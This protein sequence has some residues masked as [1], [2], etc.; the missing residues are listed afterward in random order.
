MDLEPNPKSG[1]RPAALALLVVI[2]AACSAEHYRR[3]ADE[4]VYSILA[5]KREEAGLPAREFT[6]DPPVDPLRDRLLARISQLQQESGVEGA[7][8]D[9][10][11]SPSGPF[12]QDD[13]AAAADAP[14]VLD[15]EDCLRIAA[16]NSREFQ[17]EKE[18]VYL[19]ALSLTFE[20]FVFQNQYFGGVLGTAGQTLPEERSGTVTADTGFT[21]RLASGANVVFDIGATLFRA[22]VGD[23]EESARSFL[24]L[25]ITQPLLRGA[26]RTIVQEPL[27]QSERDALYAIRQFEQFKLDLAVQ[28][29]SGMYRV[30][31]QADR[32]RNALANL[33]SLTRSRERIE[34]LAEAGRTPQFQVDQAEQDE[35]RAKN[36]WIS[37]VQSYETSLDRFKLQLGLP[38]DA[39]L[40]L[41]QS[42]LYSLRDAG[43]REIDID[44]PAAVAFALDNRLD[45]A[46]DLDRVI[47]ATRRV[48]VAKDALRTALSVSFSS[49]VNNED[50][51]LAALEFGDGT[52][53]VGA[54]LDLPFNRVAERN[55]YRS[56]LISL[57]RAERSAEAAEDNVKFDVRN[58]ARSL[59]LAEESFRIQ[60]VAL[61]LAERRVESTALLQQAGRAS[62]RDLLESQDALLESQDGLTGAL[63]DHEIARLQL[64]RDMGLLTVDQEGLSYDTSI[65]RFI[66][67]GY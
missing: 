47:D 30:L 49:R 46:N 43:L 1:R 14:L 39:D 9:L 10:D 42:E 60:Q 15:L 58:S 40:Q 33:Q 7:L 66:E 61:L 11:V 32:V 6:I 5:A 48:N 53:L 36:R 17:R 18:T 27:T 26:G 28:I 63:V 44:T 31:Q 2:T 45:F 22:F 65:D 56:S 62:T 25:T 19:A 37:Q 54:D 34:A 59:E 29:A 35:L 13:D 4:E 24:D 57:Q 20:R 64:L 51:K 50:N 55:A 38:V 23:R 8:P 52:Y 67:A 16:E 21:R 3:E 41:E 12:A